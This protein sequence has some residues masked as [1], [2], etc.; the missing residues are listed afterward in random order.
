MERITHRAAGTIEAGTENLHHIGQQVT[1]TAVSNSQSLAETHR[2]F[3]EH[4][5]DLIEDSSVNTSRTMR[6]TA[7]QWVALTS[8][9][10]V[11]R[12][13]L[14]E[15][16]RGMN[17]AVEAVLSINLDVARDLLKAANPIALANLQQ[18]FV[19]RYMSAMIDGSISVIRGVQNASQQALGPLEDR[20]TRTQADRSRLHMQQDARVA[21]VMERDVKI[22]NPDDTVQQAAR[23]MREVDSSVLPVGEGDRLV[24]MVTDR[25]L[26]LRL[27][28]E[29]KDAART[30]VRDVMTPE[31]R[32]VFED[33]SLGHVADNMAE[34]QVRRLP[35][36]NR[37]KRLVGVVSLGDIARRQDNQLVG[38]ALGG[39]VREGAMPTQSAAE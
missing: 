5:A 7:Q 15:L 14:D 36:V 2:E 12:R 21:D 24:G 16:Q 38:D 39:I 25:D 1:E 35:V 32:Y 18:H 23:L 3:L 30:K 19:Q 37:S 34:Q 20:M 8:L 13:G 4:V 22:A 27:V 33:E 17:G 11:Q 10:Q 26:A 9:P 6:E 29:G 31:V 28:A